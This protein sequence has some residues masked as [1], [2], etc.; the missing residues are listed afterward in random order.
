MLDGKP[1]KPWTIGE[2]SLDKRHF[3]DQYPVPPLPQPPKGSNV[4]AFWLTDAFNEAM[5]GIAAWP[6]KQP[7]PGERPTQTLYGRRRLDWFSRHAN[8]CST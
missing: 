7:P 5:L 8:G 3:S 1:C 6:S 2:F 4:A